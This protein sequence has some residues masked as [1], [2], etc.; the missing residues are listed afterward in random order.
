MALLGSPPTVIQYPTQHNTLNTF[1]FDHGRGHTYHSYSHQVYLDEPST[2]LDPVASRLMW[3]LLTRVAKTKTSAIVLTT[4]NMLECEAVCTR[5]GI[6]K[7]GELV[8]EKFAVYI[9]FVLY[10][11]KPTRYVILG[12]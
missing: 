9:H 3:R 5:I 1:R 8:S 6:M 7:Q 10:I 11:W 4:H 12:F 2:G